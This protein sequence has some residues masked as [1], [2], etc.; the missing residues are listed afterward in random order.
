MDCS[1]LT[2]VLTTWC[3]VSSDALSQERL[4]DRSV[5][6][7]ELHRSSTSYL[8]IVQIP[9]STASTAIRPA[10]GSGDA[11]SLDP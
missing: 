4:I 9:L 1:G 10:W 5:S 2:D 7:E 6:A 8:V 11:L 3:A